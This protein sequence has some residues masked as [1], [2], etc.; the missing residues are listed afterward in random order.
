MLRAGSGRIFMWIGRPSEKQIRPLPSTFSWSCLG[1]AMQHYT[2]AHIRLDND[3]IF[4]IGKG[5]GNR[6]W[7][8]LG[9]N[10]HWHSIV[11]KHGYSVQM[12]AFWDAEEDALLHE[13]I[14]ISCFL[15][16]K[17]NLANKTTGGD[18]GYSIS[19]ES[20]RKLSLSASARKRRPMSE[21]TKK[22]IGNANRGIVRAPE[23]VEMLRV[24]ATGKKVS[25][26]T[27]EK[28]SKI[29]KG[30]KQSKEFVEKSTKAKQK[31]VVCIDNGMIF[32]SQK[33]AAMWV[34]TNFGLEKANNKRISAA[35]NGI[36]KIAYGLKWRFAD[37]IEPKKQRSKRAT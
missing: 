28:L 29:H 19:E 14:L 26:A 16:L 23:F 6:A 3:S 15:Q 10:N 13:K 2:Y 5:Q 8:K 12:L 34:K 17:Y 33:H 21:E 11:A 37:G 30:R 32:D 35:V 7:K 31:K 36:S 25:S 20:K 24:K 18:S 27:R 22:K 1:Q 4:Y 9:R